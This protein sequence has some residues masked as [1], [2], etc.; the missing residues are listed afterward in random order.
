M[1]PC[2]LR[3]NKDTEY[4]QHAFNKIFLLLVSSTLQ[5]S[6]MDREKNIKRAQYV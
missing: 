3:Y 4:E 5:L 1:S 2:H 6:N